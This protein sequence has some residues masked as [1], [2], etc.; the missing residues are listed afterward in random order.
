MASPD[1]SKHYDARDGFYLGFG[2]TVVRRTQFAASTLNASL[3]RMRRI[4]GH[5]F[6]IKSCKSPIL[7]S[8]ACLS[9]A[10]GTPESDKPQERPPDRYKSLPTSCD[11]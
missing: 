3:Q 7:T 5:A 8:V 4:G 2:V 11:A 1:R 9:H 6:A 10:D